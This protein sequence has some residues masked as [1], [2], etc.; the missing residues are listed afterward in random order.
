M[1]RIKRTITGVS[2][3][4]WLWLIIG[5]GLAARL[6]AVLIMGDQVEVLPG[7][8]DQVSYHTLAT[9]VLDGHGFSFASE[10]WPVTQA[11]E[12]TAHWSYLYTFYLT[13][14][15]ALVGVH[16]LVARLVQAIAV[17][18]AMPWLAYRLADSLLPKTRGEGSRVR[19][20]ST[21]LRAFPY[22]LSHTPYPLLPLLAAAWVAFYPYFIYYSAALM[23]EM[24]YITAI[25]WS[26]DSAIQLAYSRKYFVRRR[27]WGSFAL[28]GLALGAAVLL[29][30]VYL[31]F[32]PFL[33]A[34]LGLTLRFSRYIPRV[35]GEAVTPA[36]SPLDPLP[37][38]ERGRYVW[39]SAAVLVI[40]V[41]PFTAWNY[42]QFGRFVLLN[43]N[44]GYAFFWANHP[45]HGNDF[46]PLFT[47]DMP[48]YQQ[49]IPAELRGLDEAALEQALMARGVDFV[50][51]DLWRYVRLSLS[52]I[53]D[54]FYFLPSADSSLLSNVTRVSSLMVALP[55]MLLG[56]LAWILKTNRQLTG[57]L[58]R[59]LGGL[60]AEPGG[61][62][63]LFI[64]VYA[65][66]HLLSWA[67][68]RY[69]LPT[70]AVMLLF[71]AYSIQSFPLR[72]E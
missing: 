36:P 19:G 40:C 67:G 49:L 2:S 16:P 64:A 70:D 69:R 1:D 39:V 63:L 68:I 42:H 65:G 55:F 61:L 51:A 41:L 47:P 57:G 59:R 33:L 14:V 4:T 24:L 15:Y 72:N 30:Q 11:G 26:L 45:I 21:Q 6:L 28:L 56:M 66:V 62:L 58:L 32:V 10:W 46:V 22:P 18:V 48:T 35:G 44:A 43:T 23:T 38:G 3:K 13:A 7:I 25:M 52:R 9:R 50:F 20:F 5:L 71:A 8:Y 34:W 29:R 12:P 53:D 17:G 60:L 37:Q 54:H 27:G 31:A